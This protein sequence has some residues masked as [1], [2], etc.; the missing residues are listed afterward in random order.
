MRATIGITAGDPAGIGLEVVLKSISSV[1]TSARWVLFTD[2]PIFERNAARF[3]PG[4]Q[5]LWIEHTSDI[6]DEPL[7]FLRDL[8]GNGSGIEF[9][10]MS[11][12][13]GRRALAYLQAASDE[14]L[15]GSIDAIVTAPVSKEAIG[16]HFHGQTDFLAERAGVRDYAMAFL[17]PT[18][19][20]VLATIHVSL[21]EA[22]VQISTEHYIRLI[23]F[24]DRQMP[25]QRI[26]VAAINPHAGEGGMFGRED[27]DVL[28]PAVRQCVGEG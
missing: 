24:V 17:A 23:R 2:R 25:G 8:G 18:F 15:A 13:A 10:K 27:I 9:G 6:S 14:A 21:R 28:A 11:A 7:L 1:L 20:V 19:K 16:G 4:V 5:S 22:L 26:A 12:E 3:N